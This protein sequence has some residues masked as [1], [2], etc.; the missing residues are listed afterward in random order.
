MNASVSF[1]EVKENWNDFSLQIPT[2][3]VFGA[4]KLSELGKETSR[5]GSRALVVAMPIMEQL[6]CLGR[7]MDSLKEA[8]LEI[9][10]WSKIRENPRSQDADEAFQVVKSR[11][12][13]C[14]V[15]LGGGSTIDL[16]K[17]IAVIAK[18][19][20]PAWDYVYTETKRKVTGALPV[21]SVP[22]TA[23]TG[24]HMTGYAVISNDELGIKSTIV[25]PMICPTAGIVDPKLTSDL[26]PGL[27]A[28]TGFDALSHSFESYINRNSRR[29]RHDGGTSVAADPASPSACCER[30]REPRKSNGTGMGGYA[31]GHPHIQ[32]GDHS[33]PRPGSGFERKVSPHSAWSIFSCELSCLHDVLV[34]GKARQVFKASLLDAEKDIFGLRGRCG[35]RERFRHRG[36]P[37]PNQPCRWPIEPRHTAIRRRD[38][39]AEI[40]SQS[41]DVLA[42]PVIASR[43]DIANLYMQSF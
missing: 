15:A 36:L 13:D 4:G 2:R 22:T 10:L 9:S 21:V 39:F 27:T 26:E 40:A 29:Y 42:N 17:A 30:S 35:Q 28:S 19:K 14:V 20:P 5:I 12:C 8:G 23:G 41:P 25:S 1:G 37:A 34:Q 43:Q 18:T 24:S 7:A 6:G 31:G 38:A 3:L 33:P 16:A 11:G 32:L